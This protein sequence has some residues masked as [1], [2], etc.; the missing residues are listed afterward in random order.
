MLLRPPVAGTVRHRIDDHDDAGRVAITVVV[1]DRPDAL[2][3][4]AGVFALHRILVLCAQ[5]YSVASGH[6]L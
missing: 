5:A 2:A 6:A 1:P 4:T 3:R